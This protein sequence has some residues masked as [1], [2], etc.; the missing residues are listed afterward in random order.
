MAPTKKSQDEEGWSEHI[1]STPYTQG[2]FWD[3]SIEAARHLA[4]RFV[5]APCNVQLAGFRRELPQRTLRARKY[6]PS[7]AMPA[8]A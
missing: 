8:N 5:V 1:C 4:G 7:T 2:A 6:E 3:L